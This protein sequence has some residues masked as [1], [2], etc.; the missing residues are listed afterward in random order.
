[1]PELNGFSDNPFKTRSDLAY[2]GSSLLRP[3]GPYKSAAGAR[4][5]LTA[6]TGTSFSET[7]AQLEGFARPLWV[8][9][10]L[11]NDRLAGFEASTDVGLDTWISGLDAGTD[12]SSPEYWGDVLSFDQRMVEMES[13][14]YSLLV[15]PRAVAPPPGPRRDRLVAWLRQINGRDIGRNNWRWFRVFV[16]L[17][18]VNV[19]G[20]PRGEVQQTVDDDLALLDSFYL[21][22]G[23]SSDGPWCDERK[24]VD[25][26]S[27]SF[28][29]Q[30]SQLLYV[31]YAGSMA[32]PGRVARYKDE[33]RSFA[34]GFWRYFAPDGAAIPFGRS[35]TY[36]FAFAAFW[37]AVALA[38]VELAAPLNSWG[39]V[40]GLLMRHLR[41]WAA[42]PHIFNTDGT[43]NI[44]FTYGNMYMSEDYNSPQSVYWC[45]KPFV[46]LEIPQDHPFW[47][48]EELP[49]PLDPSEAASSSQTHPPPII[50]F[51]KAPRHI[52]CSTPEHHFL[53]SSG[54]S[55]RVHHKGKEAKYCKFAYSSAFGFS[56]PVGTM[57]HQVGADS[58]LC[59]SID[60]GASWIARFEPFHVETV[61]F[62]QPAPGA[63]HVPTTPEP[64]ADVAAEPETL[65]AISSAWR[66]WPFLDLVI[67]TKLLPPSQNRWPGWHVR[68]HEVR[69]GG[70]SSSAVRL[71]KVR[72]ADGGFAA[73]AETAQ[74]AAIY[75]GPCGSGSPSRSDEGGIPEGWWVTEGRSLVISESGASGV[76][77]LMARAEAQKGDGEARPEVAGGVAEIIKAH[78]NS[79]LM[80]PRTLIPCVLHSFDLG[81]GPKVIRFVTAV[82]AVQ[83]GTATPGQV[84]EMW[85]KPPIILL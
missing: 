17:A 33:A 55:T 11:L 7:A 13:I 47:T 5:K 84:L 8:V 30:L 12:P 65:P 60:D 45:L 54:Q 75:E 64:P 72:F 6:A 18:L 83:K 14:A 56:V 70:S 24:Q 80:V 67:S 40:K 61:L 52:M 51:L 16:N 82:F 44:G 71:G 66:P 57:L 4:I 48:T 43:M 28:A 68:R 78:S 74:G 49:H 85:N 3:L 10:S 27:G 42:K 63:I 35:L 32:D 26:Y 1:M 39:T 36:R 2:A 15:S 59:A 62:P 9:A 58:T 23:W 31:R 53:L 41:W 69:W 77:R 81:A 29:I 76:L 50:D 79:N 73:S 46:A 38:N 19:L 37:S 22:D 20:V 21:C 25:Y 34:S